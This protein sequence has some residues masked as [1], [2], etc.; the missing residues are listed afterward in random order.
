MSPR[1]PGLPWK[2]A[3]NPGADGEIKSEN[4]NRG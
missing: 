1:R 4:V 3:I 2:D